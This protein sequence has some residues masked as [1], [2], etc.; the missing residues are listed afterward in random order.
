MATLADSNSKS[1]T[2]SLHSVDAHLRQSFSRRFPTSRESYARSK[3]R[4]V[5]ATFSQ[6]A[7][8]QRVGKPYFRRDVVTGI[9]F[10]RAP[11]GRITVCVPYEVTFHVAVRILG[12]QNLSLLCIGG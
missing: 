11:A 9:V 12:L 1:F 6:G 2:L 5:L 3:E 10:R 8:W 4:E 7:D